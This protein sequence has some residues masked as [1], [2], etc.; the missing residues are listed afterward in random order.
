MSCLVSLI[1]LGLVFLV[2]LVFYLAT[3][4][5]TARLQVEN[6]ILKAEIAAGLQEL[7]K[8]QRKLLG[9]P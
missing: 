7:A 8:Q 1:P 4:D 3:R 5:D 6:A 9:K 2:G